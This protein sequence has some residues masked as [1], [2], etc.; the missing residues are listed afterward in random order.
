MAIIDEMAIKY[1]ERDIAEEA[2]DK[3]IEEIKSELYT[4]WFSH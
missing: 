4:G 2:I 3:V 1:A